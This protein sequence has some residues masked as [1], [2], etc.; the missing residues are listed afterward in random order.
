[1]WLMIIYVIFFIS[2]KSKQQSLP[3]FDLERGF[4]LEL[5]ASEPLIK[6]P[7]DLEFDAYGNILVLE[8]PGYPF[9]DSSSKVILLKDTNHDGKMDYAKTYAENLNMATSILPYE[10]GILVAAPPYILYCIDENQ[11]EIVEK[12][13]TLMG[14]FATA[15]LQHNINGLTYGIDN[16]I[17]GA[18]GGN[19]GKPYW[20]GDSSHILDLMGQ[21]FRFHIKEKKLER[22]G[23]SS[24][25]FGI[26]MDEFG[27]IF[28]THNLTHVSQIIFPDRYIQNNKLLFEHTLQNI[29]D[30]EE[31]GLARVYP[32]G[33]QESRLNHP[34]QSGYFSGSCGITYYDGGAWG[35]EYEQTIWVTDVVLNLIHAD[36]L[37]NDKSKFRAARITNKKEFLASSDRSF[38]PVNMKVG[39]DGNLYVVDMYRKVIEHPE[40][41]PDE[42]EKSL[43]INAGKDK[44]RIY[45]ISKGKSGSS[46][47][48]TLFLEESSCIASLSHPNAWVRTTAQRILIE[49][50][51]SSD[52]KKKI[53]NIISG[54]NEVAAVHALWI[55]SEIGALNVQLLEKCMISNHEGIRENAVVIAEQFLN[56]KNIQN[57]LLALLD[58]KDDRVR[59]QAALSLSVLPKEI[60]LSFK[61]QIIAKMNVQSEETNDWNIGAFTLAAKHFPIEAMQTLIS[62]KSNSLLVASLALQVR[63]SSAGIAKILGAISSMKDDNELLIK[64]VNQF[65]QSKTP[66]EDPSIQSILAKIESD[67]ISSM[68]ALTKLSARFGIPPSDK[69]LFMSN[70]ALTQ[71]QNPNFSE[72]E[73]LALMEIIQL[74]PYKQKSLALFSCLKNQ[75]PLRVQEEALRQL[76]NY[77]EKEIGNRIIEMWSEMSPSTRRLASDLLL[78]VE[79]YH[80]ALLSALEKG[81]IQIGEMNFDLERR[82]MLIA[83]DTNPEN[84]KRANKL[85]SDE[86][87]ISRKEVVAKMKPALSLNGNQAE[88]EKVFQAICSNCHRYEN[89]GN[90]VGPVLTEINRKS[91]ESI[92]HDILDPNAAVNTQYI[93]HQ[94]KT[95]DGMLHIGVIDSENDES[96]VMKKMGGEKITFNKKGIMKMNSMGKSLMMEG[97]EGSLTHQ[98]MADLLSFM[99]KQ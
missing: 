47:D 2:C 65:N 42:M 64:I 19:S 94:I 89:I 32:I 95:K 70:K 38:R 61:D 55:L 41:I 15:N 1:M 74:V 93:S 6:D 60:S 62:S 92:M 46:F 97:I 96:V 17:Y 35:K 48:F 81:K 90:D 7:V 82:R 54:R 87:I 10:K 27:R 51:I 37:I 21:D 57:Q 76:S 5:I 53:E 4:N 88:G 80:D 3:G 83:W 12:V 75:V 26:A 58:D 39:P 31:N 50:V 23:E 8:M 78:Y 91:K 16:W 73:K 9:E 77:R 20:W 56:N 63:D 71:L 68:A 18:N 79:L 30:H 24:K 67:D 98:Q 84:R 99:Q 33:E 43:N 85:L 40:W 11:D 28:S 29:S 36:K 69:F 52:G 44:G 59:M 72:K 66:L 34:E 45:K 49:K 22:I 14:G 86:E 13:D 25:G